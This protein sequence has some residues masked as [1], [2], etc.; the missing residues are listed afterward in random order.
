MNFKDIVACRARVGLHV[1]DVSEPKNPI[2][3]ACNQIDGYVHDTE[4]FLYNGSDTR[5]DVHSYIKYL[6]QNSYTDADHTKS[7]QDDFE[8]YFVNS[9]NGTGR[10]ICLPNLD[11]KSKQ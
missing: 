6:M 8:E 3:L 1:V 5:L 2:R 4:C 10:T 9:P 11:G 7:T